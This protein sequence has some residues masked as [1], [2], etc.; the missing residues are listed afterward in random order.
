MTWRQKRFNSDLILYYLCLGEISSSC[1]TTRITFINISSFCAGLLSLA[2]LH[3]PPNIVL[4]Y[5]FQYTNRLVRVSNIVNH[6][7]SKVSC[8]HKFGCSVLEVCTMK[9]TSLFLGDS[10]KYFTVR[11]HAEKA[12]NKHI[13]INSL[14]LSH[15]K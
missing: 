5:T 7:I 6:E 4:H 14:K 2:Q 10:H 1:N 3:C 13:N 12:N 8:H 11:L 9:Y 15:K